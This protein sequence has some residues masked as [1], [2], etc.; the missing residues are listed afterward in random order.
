MTEPVA[1]AVAVTKRY[2]NTAALTDVTLAVRAGESHALV[3]R[4]GAGKSTLVS[5]LTGLQAPDGGEVRFGGGPAPPLGDRAAWR[6]LVACV[7]QK[8]TIIPTLSVAENLYLNRQ[9]DRGLISWRRLRTD[10]RVVL[11]EWGLAVDPARPAGDLNVEQRQMLEIAR[12]LSHGA[13]F[14]ILDEPTAQL[15]GA[16]IQRLF[17]RLH[18]LREQGVTFL[19]ISHHLDEIY[20]VCQAVTVLR[21]GRRVVTAP[22]GELPRP[23]LVEAMTGEAQGL[24]GTAAGRPAVREDAP[25]ALKL[26]GLRLPG[27]YEAVHLTVRA[28]EV[29]GLAG[30]GASGA[31]EVGET[32]VGLRTAREGTVEVA[33]RS[34]KAGSVP[35]AIAAGV[36]FVPHDRHA[37]GFV[38]TLSV[39]EN[40]TLS[41]A[42][43]LGRFGWVGPGRRRALA[44]RYIRDLDITTDGPQ[45]PVSGL[46]GGNQQKVVMARAL[47]GEPRVLVLLNP[48]AGVDVRSKESL[49]GIVDAAAA[50][51]AAVLV[52]SDELDDLRGCDR[53][54]VMFRGRMAG[55]YRRGWPDHG[56]VA[57]MEGVSGEPGR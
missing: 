28:G 1:S 2:G 47:S 41:I 34:V 56:L 19:Y 55:E 48:T 49:L 5:V 9:T 36:G 15:D 39:A 44:E 35:E 16:A 37:S 54:A 29:V 14:I 33:G 38:P 21:D 45:Q 42:D 46:S 57:A 27:T 18:G 43:R 32:I 4:N 30:G 10:A 3:G 23:R 11:G 31:L 53:V 7:Y 8:S 26:Q 25:V 52:V 12:A 6:R 51:G 24:T 20:E 50:A 13:R 22:V 40:A 17:R